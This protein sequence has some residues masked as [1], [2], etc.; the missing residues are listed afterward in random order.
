MKFLINVPLFAYLILLLTAVLLSRKNAPKT[1]AGFFLGE[2][3]MHPFIVTVSS[4]VASRG[5]WLLLGLTTEAYILGLSSV[6][7]IAGFVISELL[8]FLFLAPVLRHISG[9]AEEISIAGILG[10]QAKKESRLFYAVLS[11]VMILFLM[12]FIVSQLMGA[13]KTFYALYGITAT[14]GIIITGMIMLI[15]IFFGG[16]RL[17]GKMDLLHAVLILSALLSLSYILLSRHGGFSGVYHEIISSSPEFFSL[18]ALSAG[19]LTGFISLGLASAG[20]PH[21]LTK[22]MSINNSGNFRKLAIVQ[23]SLNLLLASSAVFIGIAG[24]T[25][26][27]SADSI[28]GAIEQNLY[29]GL[30]GTLYSPLFLGLILISVFASVMSGAGSQLL[31]AGSAAISDLYR[32]IARDGKRFTEMKLVFYS[33]IAMLTLMYLAIL[34]AIFIDLDYNTITLFALSGLGASFGPAVLARI[35][36]KNLTSKAVMAGVFSGAVTVVLCYS[37]PFLY[38]RV[39]GIVPGLIASSLSLYLGSLLDQ[40]MISRKYNK[41]ARYQDIIKKGSFE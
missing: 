24:R 30:G 36:W 6:W 20:N 35:L 21:V 8:L 39:Y 25:S 18:K 12:A 13:G 22:Y 4:V 23:F 1:L 3:K 5:S 16:S 26:F 2:R 7:L 28:P 41:K 10:S 31:V 9:K 11:V 29:F 32:N 37:I 27:P 19:T 38:E 33:R 15:F 40:R 14:N 17:L 34:P